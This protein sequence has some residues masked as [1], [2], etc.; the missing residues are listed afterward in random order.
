MALVQSK[1]TQIN[2]MK[3]WMARRGIPLDVIDWE[4]GSPVGLDYQ[5]P[6]SY[7]ISNLREGLQTLGYYQPEEEISQ[8][9]TGRKEVEFEG[10]RGEELRKVIEPLVE[11]LVVEKL[12]KESPEELLDTLKHIEDLKKKVQKLYDMRKAEPERKPEEPRAIRCRRCRVI[13]IPMTKEHRDKL[14]AGL[15]VHGAEADY[16]G[17]LELCPICFHDSYSHIFPLTPP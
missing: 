4:S 1:Q 5:Q 15:L 9:E 12:E 8:A 14:Y 16:Q 17:A 3:L 10:L 11:E 2:Q 13:F 7:N 6:Y